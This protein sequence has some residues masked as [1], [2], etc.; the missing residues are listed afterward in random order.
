M[1]VR[2][3]RLLGPLACLT[4]GTLLA[5]P[6]RADEGATDAPT[7]RLTRSDLELLPLHEAARALFVRDQADLVMRLEIVLGRAERVE[8][9]LR[10][11][12]GPGDKPDAGT[13]AL[14]EELARLTRSIE[15]LV[16]ELERRLQAAH[17]PEGALSRV[18]RAP[19]GALRAERLAHALVL[20]APDLSAAQRRVFE[21]L[22]PA[23]DGALLVLEAEVQRLEKAPAASQG[24][25]AAELAVADLRQRQKGV[26]KRFW[27]VVD[28]VLLTP[29]RAAV[30]RRLPT[31]LQKKD[32]GIAH[33]YLLDGLTPS[34]GVQFKALLLE[35]EAEASADTSEAKRI[36]TALAA[37][38]L[39]DP[40]RRALEQ[41]KNAVGSRL[42]DLQLRAYQQG[43]AL[44]RPEQV[45]ELISVPPH[46]TGSDRQE[47]PQKALAAI[48]T[49][50]AQ[51]AAFA[52]LAVR[53]LGTKREIEG[54]Y[55]DIQRRLKDAG[56]DSPEREMAEMMAAGLGGR[57]VTALRA[58][59]G[60]VFRDVLRPEQVEGWV[61]GLH[62][63]P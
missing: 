14:R 36:E 57:V 9:N 48:P 19:L 60:E 3:P 27:R 2:L 16:P 20:E 49:D 28:A 31:A 30:M 37:P 4:L 45:E 47:P 43:L 18:R 42:V 11:R 8:E 6:A 39:L 40:A 38:G 17:V 63:P 21:H 26:Q 54:G 46:L 22:V 25:E 55:V 59:Y 62:P 35:L 29:Q 56:P 32:D 15:E 10:A 1:S 41:E 61:L 23:V 53:Y 51:R 44:L 13:L 33:V 12:E 34:Q 5:L 24:R 52:A 50:A 58:V 7:R